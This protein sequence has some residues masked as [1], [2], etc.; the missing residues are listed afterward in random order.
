M[1][2]VA[3]KII[4]LCNNMLY[5][6]YVLRLGLTVTKYFSIPSL[7]KVVTFTCLNIKGMEDCKIIE[8]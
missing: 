1:L 7:L 3:K 8:V 2:K 6:V 4:L 5:I